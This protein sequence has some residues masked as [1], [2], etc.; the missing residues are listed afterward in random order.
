MAR[1]VLFLD[2]SETPDARLSEQ[3]ARCG[4]DV[5]TAHDAATAAEAIAQR[6]Y[7]LAVVRAGRS[8]EPGDT[9]TALAGVPVAVILEQPDPEAIVRWLEAGADTVLA[10]PVSRRELA[11]RLGALVPSGALIRSAA[12]A[13]STTFET[14]GGRYRPAIATAT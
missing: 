11:A 2:C 10:A 14:R 3:L 5:T 4:Y 8:T 13:R 7:G 12:L 9:Q 1:H 6:T